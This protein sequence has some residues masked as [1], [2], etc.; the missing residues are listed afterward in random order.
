MMRIEVKL[1]S[2]HDMDLVSLYKS[3]RIAFPETTRQVLN[4]Y[5]NKE[6][7]KVRLL[8]ANKKREKRYPSDTYRKY[9][10]Y[11]VELDE[12]NDADAIKLIE[13]ITPGCRN[14][15]IKVLLR[16]YIC[17]EIPAGYSVSGDTRLFKS[18][19]ALFHSGLDEKEI[20]QTK[21]TSDDE[22]GKK[23]KRV[24]NTESKKIKLTEPEQH[25]D[26]NNEEDKE[27]EKER[28]E[29]KSETKAVEEQKLNTVEQNTSEH[30]KETD[31]D[32]FDIDA[33]LSGAADQY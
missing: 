8:D 16:Q 22:K 33:F 25:F 10:H 1:Y 23:K 32:D 21:R 31:D 11:H 26:N 3:G 28:S 4:S 20:R 19:T 18:V 13:N 27:L 29:K 14:N 30:E 7:Y 2:Y 24:K 6:V 5:A 12:K 15:F 17:C 9:Y